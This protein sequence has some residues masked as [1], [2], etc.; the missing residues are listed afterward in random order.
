[1]SDV[2]FPYFE[3]GQA[4]K[5]SHISR[6]LDRLRLRVPLDTVTTQHY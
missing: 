5:R 6:K 3:L 4:G 1:M 2:S